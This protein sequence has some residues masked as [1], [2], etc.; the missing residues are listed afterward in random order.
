MMEEFMSL[1][2]LSLIIGASV[3]S[4]YFLVSSVQKHS[5]YILIPLFIVSWFLGYSSGLPF[6]STMYAMFVSLFGSAIAVAL[7]ETTTRNVRE[8]KEV[9]KILRWITELIISIR[10]GG[11]KGN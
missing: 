3:G 6:A 2:F 11:G 5:W 4:L 7:L 9:P 10:G 1:I 8:D